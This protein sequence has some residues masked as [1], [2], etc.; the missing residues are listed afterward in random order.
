MGLD[1][2]DRTRFKG[3][4]ATEQDLE[5]LKGMVYFLYAMKIHILS[6]EDPAVATGNMVCKV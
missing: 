3:D 4:A 5:M 1:W 2:N 6:L